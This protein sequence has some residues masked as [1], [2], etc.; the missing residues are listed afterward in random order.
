MQIMCSFEENEIQI[1]THIFNHPVFRTELFV[2]RF[3][4]GWFS[5]WYLSRWWLVMLT[6]LWPILT[7]DIIGFRDSTLSTGDVKRDWLILDGNALL[8]AIVVSS[9]CFESCMMN[10]EINSLDFKR[11]VERSWKSLVES[12]GQGSGIFYMRED[13]EQRRK[14]YNG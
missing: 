3:R 2:W 13:L 1:L 8:E 11:V 4:S 12:V 10:T 9:S 5:R 7:Y 6:I 14:K